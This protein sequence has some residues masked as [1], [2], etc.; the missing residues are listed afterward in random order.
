MRTVNHAFHAFHASRAILAGCAIPLDSVGAANRVAPVY[1]VCHACRAVFVIPS[2][3]VAPACS[4]NPRQRTPT[5]K[6]SNMTEPLNEYLRDRRGL[7]RHLADL[8]R[9]YIDPRDDVRADASPSTLVPPDTLSA[10]D[11][12]LAIHAAELLYAHDAEKVVSERVHDQKAARKAAARI[13]QRAVRMVASDNKR[14][15]D[16]RAREVRAEERELARAEKTNARP[17]SYT[18]LTLPT[19]RIV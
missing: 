17:V 12:S 7:P 13:A 6:A 8:C 2:R 10:F 15:A 11:R 16:D 1:R 4:G 9:D 3:T 5:A 19:K 18:H 14:A